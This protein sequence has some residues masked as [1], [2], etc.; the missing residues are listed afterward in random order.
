MWFTAFSYN[1]CI[2][3][4]T[5]PKSLLAPSVPQVISSP[6]STLDQS[7]Q[8]SIERFQLIFQFWQTPSSINI[9]KEL[10]TFELIHLQYQKHLK[11]HVKRFKNMYWIKKKRLNW[12]LPF[13]EQMFFLS[14]AIW[15]LPL[16]LC[17][18]WLFL[19]VLFSTASIMH[20]CAISLDRYIAIKKPIQA[21]QCNSRATAF[22][23]ITVVWL[24]SI[25]MWGMP[26]FPYGQNA[27]SG[28]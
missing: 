8:C 5:K 18:A 6:F 19:D 13:S 15:P 25:G 9:L 11:G 10:A 12:K 17:P 22:I 23:K 4:Q 20:L 28:K 2:Y 24:I 7:T 14:E 1:A 27:S 3:Y 21:N 26:L 16:A